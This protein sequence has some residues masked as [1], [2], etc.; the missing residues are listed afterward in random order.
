MS[1]NNKTIYVFSLLT[2]LIVTMF[3]SC[4]SYER[5]VS[6][7]KAVNARK[8][9][10]NFSPVPL[11]NDAKTI[12]NKWVD[13]VNYKSG[14]TI[15]FIEDNDKIVD[16]ESFPRFS[17]VKSFLVMKGLSS[18][19]NLKE[20]IGYYGEEL[21][22]NIVGIDLGTCWV[23]GSF[24][25]ELID[26]PEGETLVALILIG[27][28]YGL[29]EGKVITGRDRKPLTERI[30]A[31]TEYP[32]WIEYGLESVVAAPSAMNTQKPIVNYSASG[33]ISMSVETDDTNPMNA[34]DL[35]DLGIA[36]KHFEVGTGKGYFELG[37]GGKFNLK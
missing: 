13:D 35:V 32:K 10:R 9:E 21:V 16:N 6:L 31:E 28:T 19:E 23:G 24:H 12:I 29:V 25:K 27:N 3:S 37:N 14:L 4:F 20:K 17:N 2:L 33:E 8:A 1:K 11:T 7:K 5:S 18:D 26:V 22:L 34:F 30:I 36:K 15:E